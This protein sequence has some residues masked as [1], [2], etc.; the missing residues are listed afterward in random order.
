MFDHLF[1]FFG[2]K[3]TAPHSKTSLEQQ[4]LEKHTSRLCVSHGVCVT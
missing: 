4:S 1:Q 3:G 2:E